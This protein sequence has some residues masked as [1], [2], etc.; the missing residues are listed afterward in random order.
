MESLDGELNRILEAPSK[1]VICQPGVL[2]EFILII[3]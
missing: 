2:V 1:P 3:K